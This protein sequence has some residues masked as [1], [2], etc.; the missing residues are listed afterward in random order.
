MAI[1]S[2]FLPAL[3]VKNQK[4]PARVGLSLLYTLIYLSF[5]ERLFKYCPQASVQAS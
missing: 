1:K 5:S 2:K 3:Y 4:S